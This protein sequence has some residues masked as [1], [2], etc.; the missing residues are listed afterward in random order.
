VA[1]ACNGLPLSLE[2]TGVWFSTQK[3]PQKSKEGS[4]RL[5]NA[6]PFGEGCCVND[7][8]W[9]RLMICYNDLSHEEHEMFLDIACFLSKE[10]SSKFRVFGHGKGG[11]VFKERYRYG[12]LHHNIHQ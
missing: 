4:L 5:K 6:P 2:V 1:D 12:V 7:K 9:R 11:L 8:L 10:H 3:I